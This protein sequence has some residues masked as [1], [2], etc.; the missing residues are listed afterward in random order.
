MPEQYCANRVDRPGLIDDC[1]SAEEASCRTFL[2]ARC[3]QR[4]IVCGHCDRGQIYCASGCGQTARLLAQREAGQ[5]YQRSRNGRFA[6]AERNRRYRLRQKNVTH[7]GSP[8][9]PPDGL[10]EPDPMVAANGPSSPARELPSWR[11]HWCGRRC[12]ALVRQ[13]SLRRRRVPRRPS[14]SHR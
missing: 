3:R 10:V 7:Q 2:C 12:S 5:R 14:R 11:C 6:H 4:V 1:G 8:L 9:P 13:G